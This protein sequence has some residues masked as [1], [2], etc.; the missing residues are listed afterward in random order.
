MLSSTNDSTIEPR[1]ERFSTGCLYFSRSATASRSREHTT[2][3]S[4]SCISRCCS[5]SMFI[6]SWCSSAWLAIRSAG[7]ASSLSARCGGRSWLAFGGTIDAGRKETGLGGPAGTVP[8]IRTPLPQ[9]AGTAPGVLPSSSSQLP[10]GASA[11]AIMQPT[12]MQLR[13]RR[14]RRPASGLTDRSA[15]F[16]F[17]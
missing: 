7:T 5:A 3:S 9:P 11:V 8:L 12:H 16:S 14:S 1:R 15:A 13:Q 10:Q 2:R 6:I 17:A 4:S